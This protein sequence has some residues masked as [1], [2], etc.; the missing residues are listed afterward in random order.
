MTNHL[1]DAG[2]RDSALRQHLIDQ[3]GDTLAEDEA[4]LL[5][6]LDGISDFVESVDR[7][8]AAAAEAK[9]LAAAASQRAQALSER[10]KAASDR[11]ARIRRAILCA[12]LDA[13]R[14]SVVCTEAAVSV[15][16]GGFAVEITDPDAIPVEFL[17]IKTEPNK[18]AL[19]ARL[20][21]GEHIEGAKLVQL[22]ATLQVRT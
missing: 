3:F 2:V 7:A 5:G 15:K 6:T 17:R 11:E 13:G 9:A 8:L 12:M 21:S 1:K 20:E 18:P 4:A 14:Q 16:K 22:P 10:A 19:K